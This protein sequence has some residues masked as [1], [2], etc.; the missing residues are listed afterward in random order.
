MVTAALAFLAT[1]SARFSGVGKSRTEASSGFSK[2]VCIE[3][4]IQAR[5]DKATI[6]WFAFQSHSK[7]LKV[8]WYVQPN[9]LD[10]WTVS[11]LKDFVLQGDAV[12]LSFGPVFFNVLAPKE[13]VQLVNTQMSAFKDLFGHYPTMVESYYV[14]AYTLDYVS[15]SYPSV[16]GGVVFV[17]HESYADGFKSAGAYYMPYYPSKLNTLTPGV[18]VDKTDFVALPF[19]QRD[20]G[21]CLVHDSNL[22]N[23]DPQ[24]GVQEVQAWR[25]Y[26]RSLLNAYLNGWDSY[27]L[28][29]YMIDLS[30]PIFPGSVIAE[31]LADLQNKIISGNCT[32]LLD[33]EFVS[34]FKS[35]FSE[36]PKYDWVYSDPL[37]GSFTNHWSFSSER[38]FG[39]VSGR[40]FE[41]K[42]YSHGYE[43]CYYEAVVPYD[44]SAA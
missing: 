17:N 20:I 27:G 36:S 43:A 1:N 28:A 21:N 38:R 26:F 10:A 23:L 9:I 2:Y 16:K 13:R 5:V 44:N 39:Y 24:D 19:L 4:L 8:T 25:S 22:F 18:G 41:G 33:S 31:D 3:A 11:V 35:D 32:S 12:E 40:F 15:V 30:Y 42:S 29:L 7:N 14:D 34:V 6:S 37:S